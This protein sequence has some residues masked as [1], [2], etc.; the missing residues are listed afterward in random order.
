MDLEHGWDSIWIEPKKIAIIYELEL[1][2]IYIKVKI[3]E[4]KAIDSEIQHIVDQIVKKYK[5]LKIILSGS[6]VVTMSKR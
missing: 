6:A 2:K 3:L 5:P 4:K 1:L